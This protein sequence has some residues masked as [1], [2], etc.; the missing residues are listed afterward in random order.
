[1]SNKRKV[2]LIYGGKS[3]EHEVSVHT[4]L[5]V[6]NAV[7]KARYEVL[8]IYI[9]VNGQWV[10]GP[11]IEREI[12]HVNELRFTLKD[13]QA[14]N[15]FTLNNTV[16]VVFPVIHGPNGEDGTLQGFLELID[17]PYVGSG[18][19]GSSVGMDKIMMK[20]VF[21]NAGLPQGKYKSYLR[22]ELET[23]FEAICNDIEAEI[24]LPCFVKPANMGSSVGISKAK[25][26]QGLVEALRLAARFDRKVIVEAFI[27]GRE[28]EI[29]VLG[30]EYP[31]TSVVGEIVSGN[32]FYDYEAKYKSN[33][34]RLDIPANV[35]DSVVSRMKK[36]AA[37]A[38]LALDCSGLSR[39]DF[40]WDEAKDELY[41][42][43]INTMPGFTPFSMY[44]MLWK[45]AGVP[46]AELIDRL[47]DFGIE[48]HEEKK[49]NALV[50][51]QFND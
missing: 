29:G 23:N 22:S 42:N 40:F 37:Q 48:R 20:E 35:P 1:M 51:E 34:T 5:S 14:P 33:N 50:A 26:R 41:I 19:L 18:V 38:F 39:V 4:A 3:S 31:D 32:E 47:I 30:N 27:S 9:D 43:E 15:V 11:W 46:Y 2:G 12:T 16:D 13:Y 45:E 17:V 6:I 10:Q 28:L 44:P 21:G 36:L 7:D 25:N 24:G 49:A 8:P